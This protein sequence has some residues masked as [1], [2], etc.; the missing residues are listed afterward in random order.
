MNKK[1][2]SE[3]DIHRLFIDPALERSGWQFGTQIVQEYTLTARRVISRGPT[4]SKAEG[5]RAD[6]VFFYKPNIPIAVVEAKDNNHALKSGI[7][8][9]LDYAEA[10]DA[11]FAFT[12]N[13]DGFFLHDRSTTVGPIKTEFPL[14]ALPTY[15]PTLYAS[16]TISR[17]TVTKP[18][19]CWTPCWTSMPTTASA[20]SKPPMYCRCAP[21]TSLERPRKSFGI[22]AT[23]GTSKPPSAN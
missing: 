21:R 5:R 15:A 3:A 9:A 16:R 18:E 12:D 19:R 10:L 7:Q 14:D 6:Y 22:L 20:P 1:L 8:Q 23:K 17:P 13:S 11:P 4:R 2:L